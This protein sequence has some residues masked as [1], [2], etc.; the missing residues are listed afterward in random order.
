MQTWSEPCRIGPI[1]MTLAREY[2]GR[3]PKVFAPPDQ[4]VEAAMH[5]I[6]GKNFMS[7]SDAISRRT[8]R[9]MQYVQ[10]HLTET[11][12]VAAF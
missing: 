9:P 11:G 2:F 8:E 12:T 10:F 5:D 4:A 1:D 7:I 6:T 3:P